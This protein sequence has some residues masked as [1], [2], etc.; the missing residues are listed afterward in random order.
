MTETH[1][2][3]TS[4]ILPVERLGF[5]YIIGT[6]DPF[7]PKLTAHNSQVAVSALY[8]N[9]TV[10]IQLK[11]ESNSSLTYQNDQ[12][13]SGDKLTLN[14]FESFKF[15]KQADLTGTLVGADLPVAVFTGNRCKKLQTFG[16]CSHLMEQLPPIDDL[17]DEFIVPPSLE[18]GGSKVRINPY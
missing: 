14:K 11:F 7:S 16:Y 5:R 8:D 2:S 15:C 13:F 1:N 4:L 18:F 17:D 9:T 3:D 6:T 12:Y 10:T